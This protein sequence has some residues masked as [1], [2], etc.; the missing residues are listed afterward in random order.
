[1]LPPSPTRPELQGSPTRGLFPRQHCLAVRSGRLA[2]PQRVVVQEDGERP[3]PAH[4]TWAG[5]R[6]A[7]GKPRFACEKWG[8]PS[9]APRCPGAWEAAA[10]CVPLPRAQSGCPMQ[11]CPGRHEQH[12]KADAAARGAE[13]KRQSTFLSSLGLAAQLQ[14]QL[15]HGSQR[16]LPLCM[17][18]IWD[19]QKPSWKLFIKPLPAPSSTCH[20]RWGPCGAHSLPSHTQRP[21]PPS[22]PRAD[23]H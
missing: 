6:G 20:Q 15:Y 3:L 9:Q 17:A 21:R 11:R 12:P 10:W 22:V 18:L 1:M 4:S 5:R 14:L 2:A 16:A 8:E 13:R 7:K 23:L 19:E